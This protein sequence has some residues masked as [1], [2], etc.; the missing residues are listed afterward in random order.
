MIDFNLELN[1]ALEAVK[2]FDNV[3]YINPTVSHF[4]CKRNFATLY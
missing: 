3:R 1:M 4:G 2:A